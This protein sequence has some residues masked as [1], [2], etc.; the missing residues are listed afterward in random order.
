MVGDPSGR[1]T[2]RQAMAASIREQN[3]TKIS[4]QLRNLL[5]NLDATI[6]RLGFPH[7]QTG[8]GLV[9]DNFD[10]FKD[11]NALQLLSTMAAG[12]SMGPMLG[13]DS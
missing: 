7:G 1:T 6:I 4:Q 9:L 10:W 11:T 8:Q 3:R 5:R 13:R 2:A 12:M